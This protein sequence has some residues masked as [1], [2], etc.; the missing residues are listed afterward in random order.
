M[1]R[2]AGRRSLALVFVAL[3]LAALATSYAVHRGLPRYAF[4]I[5]T[6]LILVAALLAAGI[7]LWRDRGYGHVYALAWLGVGAGLG[8]LALLAIVLFAGGLAMAFTGFGDPGL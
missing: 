8:A 7:G 3:A 2:P 6:E 1:I 5:G 4:S